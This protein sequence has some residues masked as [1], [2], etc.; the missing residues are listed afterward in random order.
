MAKGFKHGAGGGASLNFKVV[1]GTT[2]PASPKE[3]TIWVNT[4]AEIT[5]WIFSSTEPENPSEGM[6]WISTGVSS[7]IAFNALKKNSVMVYPF[8]AS[9]YGGGTWVSVAVKAYIG[10][11]WGDTKLYIYKNGNTY[12]AL[13]GGLANFGASFAL[14]EDHIYANIKANSGL[15]RTVNPIDLTNI[16]TLYCEVFVNT[17]ASYDSKRLILCVWDGAPT[18]YA[19]SLNN[20]IASTTYNALGASEVAVTMILDVSNIKGKKYVGISGS[21]GSTGAKIYASI[22]EIRGEA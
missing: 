14:N 6:V 7:N 16:S 18:D 9:Q 4:D 22:T 11:V 5:S 1:G 3:N 8:A 20:P 21:S 12:D 17:S 2:E 10:D 13:T 15:V 19:D